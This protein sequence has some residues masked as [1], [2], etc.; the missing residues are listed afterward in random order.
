MQELIAP[1][2][3]EFYDQA[4]RLRGTKADLTQA[5]TTMTGIDIKVLS[6]SSILSIIPIARRMSW[7]ADRQ[8][9]RLEDIAY[10]LMGI[11]DINMPLLYGE[12]E[13][14]FIRLQEEI[15]KET[16]DLSLF[17]WQA[18]KTKKHDCG[19]P[20]GPKYRGIFASS[21]AEF[22]NAGDIVLRSDRK[23]NEEFV[24]TNKGL[25]INTRL[26]GCSY[27]GYVLSLNCSRQG[28]PKHEIGIDLSFLGAS[29]YARKRPQEL[30]TAAERVIASP[31]KTI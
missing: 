15:V 22:A 23:F 31:P 1:K 26:A 14:A 9:T 27:G 12:G 10:S 4:W 17:A 5:I 11:F 25:R 7:A 16:N 18:V 19:Q 13:K 21:P 24:M 28:Q 3:V 8:T 2:I 30:A 6:D 29:I 20:M